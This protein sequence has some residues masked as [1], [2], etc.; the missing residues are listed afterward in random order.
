MT[1]HS[2]LSDKLAALGGLIS[3]ILRDPD[4]PEPLRSELAAITPNLRNELNRERQAEIDSIEAEKIL[5]EIAS[6]L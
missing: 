5:P 6:R 2:P 3:E 1:S 4:T